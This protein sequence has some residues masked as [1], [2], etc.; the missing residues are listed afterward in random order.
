MLSV[1]KS[2]GVPLVCLA[3]H[4]LCVPLCCSLYMCVC[5]GV[6]CVFV[7][8]S[9]QLASEANKLKEAQKVIS[10]AECQVQVGDTVPLPS[11]SFFWHG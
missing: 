9:V 11:L 7:C 10:E 1:N 5:L 2:T 6:C 3:N 4:P 8:P